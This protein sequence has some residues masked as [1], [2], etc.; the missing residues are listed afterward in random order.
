[1]DTTRTTSPSLAWGRGCHL[2]DMSAQHGGCS[3]F[4]TVNIE[5]RAGYINFN[6]C[7]MPQRR[8]SLQRVCW[9]CMC[10]PYPRHIPQQSKRGELGLAGCRLQYAKCTSSSSY[11]HLSNAQPARVDA[12]AAVSAR[13]P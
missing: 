1:M 3:P 10:P 2:V 7:A 9:S 8:V 4:P 11:H 5:T 13:E 12:I 6:S